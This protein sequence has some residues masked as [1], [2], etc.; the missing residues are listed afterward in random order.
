M[1]FI[2]VSTDIALNSM[3]VIYFVLYP[4]S[5][6]SLVTPLYTTLTFARVDP[7]IRVI[8]VFTTVTKPADLNVARRH[9]VL[10]FLSKNRFHCHTVLTLRMENEL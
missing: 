9:L 7:R 2:P 3:D 10:N 6:T 8:T 1:Y 4:G 5:K